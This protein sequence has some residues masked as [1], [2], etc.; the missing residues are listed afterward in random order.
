[1][2]S[3][4]AGLM[5]ARASSACVDLENYGHLA[6]LLTLTDLDAELGTRSYDIVPG[7]S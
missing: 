2:T 4:R 3:L 6:T 1:M 7:V 5:V